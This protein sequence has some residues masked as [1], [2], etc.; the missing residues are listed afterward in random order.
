[1]AVELLSRESLHLEGIFQDERQRATFVAERRKAAS[2]P[3]ALLTITELLAAEGK[4][5]PEG[6]F[7]HIEEL[8][9]EEPSN[10]PSPVCT[11]PALSLTSAL[12]LPTVPAPAGRCVRCRKSVLNKQCT[13]RLCR[14]CCKQH[15]ETCAVTNHQSSKRQRIHPPH[16]DTINEAIQS[17]E[18]VYV[19][20]TGGSTPGRIRALQPIRWLVEWISFQ[21]VEHGVENAVE[22]T[23]KLSRVAQCAY[24]R[25]D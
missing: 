11:A 14:Q 2:P 21:A 12:P 15:P 25:W 16:S 18:I 5:L 8:T 7:L 10:T 17:S 23:Y 9:D 22:K 3:P 1:M 19:E 24:I 6:E 4:V 20:Y 13:H